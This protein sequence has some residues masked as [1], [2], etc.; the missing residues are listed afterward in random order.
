MVCTPCSAQ[1]FFEPASLPTFP[2][3]SLIHQRLCLLY[4]QDFSLTQARS[5]DAGLELTVCSG[6]P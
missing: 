4:S 2:R 6:W 3:E 5:Q 1:S